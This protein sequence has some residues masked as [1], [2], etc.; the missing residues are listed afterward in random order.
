VPLSGEITIKNLNV[1]VDK[2]D[3]QVSLTFVLENGLAKD[4]DGC[5][6]G[7]L[8][9]SSGDEALVDPYQY[10]ECDGF[11]PMEV[12]GVASFCAD[13]AY[14]SACDYGVYSGVTTGVLEVHGMS[15]NATSHPWE[16]AGTEYTLTLAFIMSDAE[17]VETTATAVIQ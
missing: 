7:S 1:T 15:D 11:D 2:V 10:G 14:N 6:A 3:G 9:A 17:L 4:I 5:N 16:A 12:D 8:S 13:S